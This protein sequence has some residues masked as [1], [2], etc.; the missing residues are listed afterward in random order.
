MAPNSDSLSLPKLELPL[1]Q[2]S[3]DFSSEWETTT[4][5]FPK[6]LKDKWTLLY[7]YP[8]DDTP[9][10]T[11]QACGYR[12]RISEFK[13]L[14]ANVFGVSPDSLDS[15]DAFVKKFNLN[16]PLITDSENILSRALGVY[17]RHEQ[18]GKVYEGISR[19]TFL[20][21]KNAQIVQSWRQVDPLSTVEDTLTALKNLG[22]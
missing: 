18:K 22:L 17:G 6:Q 1:I 12:D 21:N 5:H 10:C 11:R 20:I 8:K 4:I 2:P 3:T 14:D 13:N 15:H 7:F 9:G 19:D 16:F